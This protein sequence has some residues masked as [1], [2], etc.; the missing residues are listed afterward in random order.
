MNDSGA[1]G[2][3]PTAHRVLSDL[4]SSLAK[5]PHGLR[6]R[7]TEGTQPAVGG[8]NVFAVPEAFQ[9]VGKIQI[10]VSCPGSCPGSG[11]RPGSGSGPGESD[12][13]GVD[14]VMEGGGLLVIYERRA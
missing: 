3:R 5:E 6:V 2:Y 1:H 14:G 13:R 9:L 10:K 8:K 4:N 11:S 12:A 7:P